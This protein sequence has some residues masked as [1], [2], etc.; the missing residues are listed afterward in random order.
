VLAQRGPSA[1]PLIGHLVELRRDPTEFLTKCAREYGDV[2]PLRLGRR[3]ALLINDPEL[4]EQV[5]VVRHEDFIKSQGYRL[6][7]PLVGHG[8]LTSE[9]A[10]WLR[11][12]RLAQPAFHR[13]RIDLYG[14]VMLSFTTRLLAQWAPREQRDIYEDMTRLTLA[15]V[16][17]A[18]FG[19]DVER[20]AAD[21]GDTVSSALRWTTRVVHGPSALLP[22]YVPTPSRVALALAVRRVD[23]VI[24][25][26]IDEHRRA[27]DTGD[28]LSMLLRVATDGSPAMSDRQLRDEVLT[29]FL[30]GHETTASALSWACHLLAESPNVQDRLVAEIATVTGSR[31]VNAGDARALRYAEAVIYEAMRLYP[32]VFFIGREATRDVDVGP[33]RIPR[34]TTVVLSQWV[35]HRDPKRF[36]DPESFLP[37]RWLADDE[38][39][40][41]F[42]YFPFGGGPRTCIG[43]SFARLEATLVLAAVA[44]QFRF[45]SVAGRVVKVE[46]MPLTTRPKGGLP[47]IVERRNNEASG[48]ANSRP[49]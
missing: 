10:L 6:A 49:T 40:P 3:R 25:G 33:H 34:G 15:I 42:S 12:R 37:E 41:K 44:Q 1:P 48:T 35:V 9:G 26:I 11:Q 46:A 45:R 18:L 43:A 13:Q 29:L 5:L 39:R 38:D 24:Y 14:D 20:D 22:A 32:P 31:L 27:A 16:C 8:L 7:K 36:P 28:L 30:A 19:A 4:I 23:R 17:K 2:V 47:M 21:L